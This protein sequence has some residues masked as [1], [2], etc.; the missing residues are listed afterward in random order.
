MA[1]ESSNADGTRWAKI[2]KAM[3]GDI[4][5]VA[6]FWAVVSV[7]GL[8]CLGLYAGNLG[9]AI[10][11]GLAIWALGVGML[12]ATL[13]FLFGIPKVLQTPRAPAVPAVD[14]TGARSDERATTET[15]YVQ[16]VNTNLEDISDWLTKII[17]GVGLVELKKLPPFINGVADRIQGVA[18]PAGHS[19][20]L[21]LLAFFASTG[22]LFGY[23]LTRLYLQGALARA[24]QGSSENLSEL[25]EK[26]NQI[27]LQLKDANAPQ[28]PPS[29]ETN[30]IQS[31][32][33]LA[34]EYL[35]VND[36]DPVRRL[37]IKNE[38]AK[39]LHTTALQNGV[40]R[41]ALANETNEAMIL[42]LASLVLASPVVEDMP[43]LLKAGA[44]A[45][46]LH[47]QYRVVMALA[48]LYRQNLA[49]P[50]FREPANALLRLYLE[51]ANRPLRDAIRATVELM[52]SH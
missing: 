28:S 46:R 42:T 4:Q 21:A 5:I 27:R 1:A 14:A 29:H 39:Q 3:D 2:L 32:E 30:S 45:T 6:S 37:A 23:L 8:G 43:R 47:V 16:R 24:D 36:P 35:A 31:L 26:S 11:G 20:G 13:G 15:G 19:V 25:Y 10:F 52:E 22:F 38:L 44:H 18:G 51:R 50:A 17:V 12:S 7:V 33:A 49:Q 34:K 40:S 9:W 48:E 41:D